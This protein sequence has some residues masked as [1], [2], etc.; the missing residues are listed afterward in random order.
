MC[1]I[2]Y[3]QAKVNRRWIIKYRE[4]ACALAMKRAWALE[5]AGYANEKAF[6]WRKFCHEVR[7]YPRGLLAEKFKSLA[8]STPNIT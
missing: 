6:H 5:T 7:S 2:D 1:L 8:T 4:E 3:F